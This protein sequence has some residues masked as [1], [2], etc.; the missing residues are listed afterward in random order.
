MGG[1]EWAAEDSPDLLVAPRGAGSAPFSAR[2][3]CVKPRPLAAGWLPLARAQAGTAGCLPPRAFLASVG[4][5]GPSLIVPS[6]YS[7]G[8]CQSLST[9]YSI[10]VAAVSGAILGQ[11]KLSP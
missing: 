3:H 10:N 4:P 8:S 2:S 7:M 11:I 5:A 9:C 1:R 6:I